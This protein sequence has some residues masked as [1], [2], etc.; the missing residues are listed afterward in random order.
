MPWGF[1][2]CVWL[3]LKLSY[4]DTWLPLPFISTCGKQRGTFVSRFYESPLRSLISWSRY[5]YFFLSIDSHNKQTNCLESTWEHQP[6][7][8]MRETPELHSLCKCRAEHPTFISVCRVSCS[9][10]DSHSIQQF[11]VEPL[12]CRHKHRRVIDTNQ[13]PSQVLTVA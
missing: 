5:Y 3:F 4:Q 12:P 1:C 2:V 6:S 13:H 8:L 7:A 11:F 9:S 10:P